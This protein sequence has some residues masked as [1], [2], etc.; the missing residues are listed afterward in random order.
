[1]E[2][3]TEPR[4]RTWMEAR[5]VICAVLILAVGEDEARRLMR[6]ADMAPEAGGMS[7]D[8]L[9]LRVDE[10]AAMLGV[11]RAHLYNMITRGEVRAVRLGRTVRIP[12][13][14]VRRLL[15]GGTREAVM[16]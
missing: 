16:A 2:L 12:S 7:D 3:T 14:E 11:G 10:A 6:L 1:M 5:T 15:S 8:R 9:V 13:A 4:A